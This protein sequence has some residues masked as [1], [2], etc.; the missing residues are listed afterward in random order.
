MTFR[1]PRIIQDNLRFLCVEV[2]SQITNLES[3]FASPTM[4]MARRILDRSGYAYNLKSRI[5]AACVNQLSVKKKVGA[6]RLAL[7]STEFIATDLE[8]IAEFCRDCISQLEYVDQN[9]VLQL[10]VHKTTL[11]AL[12]EGIELIVPAISENDT[13]MA[14]KIG[15]FEEQIEASYQ[16]VLSYYID[17]LKK[18]S[19]TEDLTRGLFVAQTVRQMGAALRHISEAMISASLG[20]PVNFE[21]YFSLQSLV[22]GLD[23]GEKS[24]QI[25]P[26]AETRS[27]SAISGITSAKNGS[28]DDYLA[29]FKDGVKSKVKEERE[30][31]NSWH[32]I[33][34]G[35]APKI[36]SYEKRGQSAALLIEH[37][38]G[39][40]FEQIVLDENSELLQESL[41]QLGNTLKS[42]WRETHT[43]KPVSAQFMAQL[44][45]R[46]DEVYKIHPEFR[47]GESAIC[48][49]K[50]PS[51]DEL[52]KNASEIERNFKAPF[53]VY[54]H[55]DFNVDNII[56]DPVEKRINF[57]DLH[58][59]RYMDYVQDVSVFMVSNYRLQVVDKPT[60]TRIMLL[61]QDVYRIAKRYANKMG[62]TS[63]EIRLALGLARS[64]MTSTRFI[65]DRSLARSMYYRARYLIERVLAVNPDKADR[66]RIPLKEIFVD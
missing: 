48:G 31:V 35:L 62:D 63:F 53:S 45:K 51:F 56:Y 30:G 50:I 44:Q 21:R 36:L 60:R 65:L 8:R 5:H 22:D 14:L 39:F 43:P 11:Q 52:V 10:H 18:K 40:T 6:E 38:P 16:Q 29:I 54:I 2:D 27:G 34:P 3:Y 26:I 17:A 9:E 33:Y 19:C 59:S 15:Q 55:G 4:S 12:R 37:L 64:F 47:R 46:L 7:R 58:R 20:Q 13:Q 57:I 32:E 42:V 23:S 41:Q 28:A 49:C 25:E 1:L 61:A 24:L 66:F